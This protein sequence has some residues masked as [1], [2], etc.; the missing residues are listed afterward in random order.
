MIYI[1]QITNTVS[2]DLRNSYPYNVLSIANLE[3]L[4]FKRPVTF[5]IGDNGT[6]KST[7]IESIAIN[8]GFNPEGGSR[9]FNFNTQNSHSDLFKDIHLSRTTNRNKDG[10]F[11][12]AESFY[13][14]ASEVDRLYAD[15][16]RDNLIKNYGGSLHE[17]SHGESFLS[18]LQHRFGSN[19]LYILDEP[20]SALS[21]TSQLAALKR[22][23]DLVNHRSQFI[24]STHSPILMS[25]PGA[26]IYCVTH[27]GL[28]LIDFEDTEQFKITKYFMN[29]YKGMLSELGLTEE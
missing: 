12:R 22:I 10:Y 18:L 20:E 1:S 8:A 4:E 15:E 23:K 3:R 17:R 19:G 7:L 26:E 24:I 21:V 11:L 13:N 2:K 16:S 25:Y 9:D 5:I 14:V 29:N 28:Q 27:N 6:G